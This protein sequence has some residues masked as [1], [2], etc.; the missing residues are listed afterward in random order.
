M[1]KISHLLRKI[2]N[3]M[4]FAF[5]LAVCFGLSI[6]GS[7]LS[8]ASGAA[9]TKVE[10]TNEHAIGILVG[11]TLISSICVVFLYLRG[12][13]IWEKLRF[14]PSWKGIIIA[15]G[16]L[17]ATYIAYA[18][19]FNMVY[20]SVGKENFAIAKYS[21]SADLVLILAVSLINPLFEE[22]FVVGY[23]FDKMQRHSVVLIVIISTLIRVSY[24]LYQG[25]IG[26]IS[27]VPLGVFFA[28]VYSRTKNLMPLYLAHAVMDLLGL[29]FQPSQ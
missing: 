7:I 16:L 28:I 21:I 5:V 1:K 19:L 27:M 2:P 14:S 11:E 20:L 15:F 29:I 18:V 26:I 24:H 3:W 17:I 22:T 4:E 8:F 12:Y 13:K 23:V 10:F 25:W 6:V 9:F